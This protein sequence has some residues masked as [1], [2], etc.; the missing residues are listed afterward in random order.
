MSEP[1]LHLSDFTT[2]GN[3]DDG[4]GVPT[5][6][7]SL[8]DRANE[9]LDLPPGWDAEGAAPLD[10]KR[11]RAAL[12]LLVHTAPRDAPTPALIPLG[13][14]SVQ[15]EWHQEGIDLEIEVETPHRFTILFRDR[16]PGEGWEATVTEKSRRLR[17]VLAELAERARATSVRTG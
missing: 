5:W 9:L 14:G 3:A 11:V 12:D 15:L 13:V 10:R 8:V 2:A 4:V 16:A 1:R 7:P 6:L 17:S